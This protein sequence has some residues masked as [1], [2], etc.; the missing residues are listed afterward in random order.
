MF[1]VSTPFLLRSACPGGTPEPFPPCKFSIFT[2]QRWDVYIRGKRGG[3]FWTPVCMYIAAGGIAL[4]FSYTFLCL[5]PLCFQFAN[6]LLLLSNLTIT[7]KMNSQITHCWNKP[8]DDS[9]LRG[10]GPHV[11]AQINM[12]CR[13]G[14]SCFCNCQMIMAYAFIP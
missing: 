9:K 5:C 1:G 12:M 3:D 2:M 4:W 11:M 13:L 7:W 10:P 6:G 14:S 8:I